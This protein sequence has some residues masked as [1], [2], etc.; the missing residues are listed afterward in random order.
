[1]IPPNDSQDPLRSPPKE[2]VGDYNGLR[3]YT[4]YYTWLITVFEDSAEILEGLRWIIC[5]PLE[6]SLR[7]PKGHVRLS[8]EIVAFLLNYNELNAYKS[9]GS[10]GTYICPPS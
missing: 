6:G 7:A 2:R 8:I 3:R 1:M 10:K 5:C 4:T 9:K